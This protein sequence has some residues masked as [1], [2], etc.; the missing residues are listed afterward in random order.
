MHRYGTLEDP[1]LETISAT[2]KPS[3]IGYEKILGK[4]ISFDTDSMPQLAPQKESAY[5]AKTGVSI[6]LNGKSVHQCSLTLVALRPGDGT[7][8]FQNRGNIGN[9]VFPQGVPDGY[10]AGLIPRSK[11]EIRL[12]AMIHLGCI[13]FEQDAFF[14]YAGCLEEVV[15]DGEEKR[16]KPCIMLGMSENGFNAAFYGGG[17]EVPIPVLY[18]TTGYLADGTR[19]GDPQAIW[20]PTR[21]APSMQIVGFLSYHM[22][23]GVRDDLILKALRRGV[24]PLFTD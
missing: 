2:L 1:D 13:N 14:T 15:W 20:Y 18:L 21:L 17:C 24:V 22:R 6:I 4:S 5:T 16:I 23:S 9:I 7:G 8:A 19:F 12:E 3:L 11:E 10:C